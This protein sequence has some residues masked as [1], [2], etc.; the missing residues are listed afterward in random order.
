MKG[1]LTLKTETAEKDKSAQ[2]Y[3]FPVRRILWDLGVHDAT[4]GG[5]SSLLMCWS[6]HTSKALHVSCPTNH[7][8]SYCLKSWGPFQLGNIRAHVFGW[9]LVFEVKRCWEIL[10]LPCACMGTHACGRFPLYYRLSLLSHLLTGQNERSYTEY[11]RNP[12]SQHW[13]LPHIY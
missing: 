10:K 8:I 6:F 4:P 3:S 12:A 5:I 13:L 11:E 2:D 7:F 1:A 9:I